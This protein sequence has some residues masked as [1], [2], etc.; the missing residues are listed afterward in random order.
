MQAAPDHERKTGQCGCVTGRDPETGVIRAYSKCFFHVKELLKEHVQEAKHYKSLGAL[1]HPEAYLHEFE[2]YL[3]EIPLGAGRFLEIGAGTSPYVE[4]IRSRGYHY[5]AIEP[6]P[7]AANWLHYEHQSSITVLE[8]NWSDVKLDEKASH[9]L[10]AH[11]LEHMEHAP[12][13]I[14]KIS[15]NLTPGGLC[16]IVV[17]NDDDLY[18]P[19]HWWFF[20]EESLTKTIERSGLEL[21]RLTKAKI[22]DREHFLYCVA[23]KPQPTQTSSGQ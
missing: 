6:S 20:N 21:L 3:G 10:A 2:K 13:A 12:Q 8:A 15:D 22:I 18:N 1:D 14:R 7:F 17:P 19:D 4:L 9:V 5:T 16:F 11:S 23:R